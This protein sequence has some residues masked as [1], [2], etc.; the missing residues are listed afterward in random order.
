MRSW[1]NASIAS[2]G[3]M[4]TLG[5]VRG[6]QARGTS[7]SAAELKDLGAALVSDHLMPA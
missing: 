3:R 1:R 2:A 5:L 4:V 7:E 6:T